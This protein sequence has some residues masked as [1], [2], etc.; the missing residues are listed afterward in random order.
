M[1]KFI[2]EDISRGRDPNK[3]YLKY[4]MGVDRSRARMHGRF[5][6]SALNT[7]ISIYSKRNFNRFDHFFQIIFCDYIFH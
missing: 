4:L 2:W 5:K 3:K 6:I 7:V 1:A